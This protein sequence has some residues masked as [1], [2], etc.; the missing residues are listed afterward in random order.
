MAISDKHYHP[1]VAAR[2]RSLVAAHDWEGV[3]TYLSG[4]SN[5]QF[6]TAGYLLAEAHAPTL[7]ADE[8]WPMVTSLVQYNSRALLV[9][10]LHPIAKRLEASSL[11]IDDPGFVALTEILRGN[12]IDVQKT[13]LQLLPS[14]AQPE[15]VER[16]FALLGVEQGVA[17]IPYLLRTPTL[18]ASYILLQSLR[19]V[20]HDRSLL[21][22]TVY[23][24]IKRGDALSYNLAA[25]L[26][27]IFGLEEVQ[28]TFSLKV[29]PYQLA[30]Y[31]S[32]FP[33]FCQAL[34]F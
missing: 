8:L 34:R 31:E 15:Q 28:G 4:L 21:I 29:E 20:E 10:L 5:A 30:R 27:A 33:A 18:S 26:R 11:S 23:F 6:R 16:L 32:S 3:I 13:L 17:R 14:L 19:H 22:R 24:L 12:D 25:L 2:L 9:T 1:V 7:S